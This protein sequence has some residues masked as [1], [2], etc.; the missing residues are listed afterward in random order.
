MAQVQFV[1]S[2]KGCPR[3]GYYVSVGEGA[4]RYTLR[5][6][7][8]ERIWVKDPLGRGAD[9][10]M[11]HRDQFVRTL[12][13]DYEQA[14]AN[15]IRY[16]RGK[17]SPEDVVPVHIRPFE[18]YEDERTEHVQVGDE[19][20][21]FGK[22][23]G[24]RVRDI[25]D[26]DYLLWLGLES[27]IAKGHKHREVL[28]AVASQVLALTGK[29]L[30]D[31]RSE[32]ID[33]APLSL[34]KAIAAN[35]WLRNVLTQDL[36]LEVFEGESR[37]GYQDVLFRYQHQGRSDFV[38]DMAN[39]LLIKGEPVQSL[40]ERQVSA[41]KRVYCRDVAETRDAKAEAYRAAGQRF[42]SLFKGD[43]ASRD[44]CQG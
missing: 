23:K 12:A 29:S 39:H 35:E 5:R 28:D 20:L 18:L 32:K 7:F 17:G 44:N 42:D 21:P 16:F 2:D 9:P 26:K 24:T 8:I 6:A 19:V 13:K 22:H 15:L 43:S 4:K 36:E 31:W 38:S 1:E 25:T 14:K 41:L 27:F 30:V 33:R 3:E 11:V 40:T 10:R 34:A 37:N